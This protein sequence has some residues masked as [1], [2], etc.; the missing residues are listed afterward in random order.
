[1]TE[2]RILVRELVCCLGCESFDLPGGSW[3][4]DA[5]Y[6]SVTDASALLGVPKFTLWR[7]IAD[8]GV[9]LDPWRW[10]SLDWVMAILHWREEAR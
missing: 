3:P 2:R 4:C 1:M 10:V 6:V 8:G 7:H 9:P 5:R